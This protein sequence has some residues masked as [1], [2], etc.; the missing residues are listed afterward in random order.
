MLAIVVNFK[1]V[2]IRDAL[3][4][5]YPDPARTGIFWGKEFSINYEL[6][7]WREGKWRAKVM[8][9]QYE[10]RRGTQT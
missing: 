2:L 1:S 6:Y 10:G 7:T 9:V 5:Q 4:A 3:E 8:R